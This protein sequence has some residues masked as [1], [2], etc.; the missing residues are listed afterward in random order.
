MFALLLTTSALALAPQCDGPLEESDWRVALAA[1]DRY[2]SQKD[3]LNAGRLVSWTRQRV[4]CLE[5]LVQ[6][7]DIGRFAQQAAFIASLEEDTDQAESWAR[8]AASVGTELQTPGWLPESHPAP[9]VLQ[10]TDSASW[11][12]PRD[13]QLR[14][15]P[16]G[17]LGRHRRRL[18]GE[19]ALDP[20]VLVPP[21]GLAVV[22]VAV[23]P[24]VD[25]SLRRQGKG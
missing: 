2:L 20:V 14:S 21:V 15:P 19:G 1:T 24:D 3:F 6:P 8:L 7:G 11:F 22:P 25:R 4:P 23:V 13:G 12:D 17:G 18:P 9:D 16:G 10:Q 5:T